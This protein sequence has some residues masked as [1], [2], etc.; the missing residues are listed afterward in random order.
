MASSPLVWQPSAGRAKRNCLT[1]RYNCF[2]CYDCYSPYY[3][4]G[5]YNCC[6][7]SVPVYGSYVPPP[8]E[9]EVYYKKSVK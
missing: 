6:P 4:Y 7:D 3:C 2:G 1:I 5:W 8:V 9:V